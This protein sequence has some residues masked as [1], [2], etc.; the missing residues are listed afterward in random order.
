LFFSK[1]IVVSLLLHAPL[2]AQGHRSIRGEVLSPQPFLNGSYFAQLYDPNGHHVVERTPVLPGG[3][4]DFHDAPSGPC[5]V[6]I[7]TDG[8]DIVV[9][10]PVDS[11]A[12]AAPL[13][14]R[15]PEQNKPKAISGLVSLTALQH[16][17]THKA[18]S[19]VAKAEKFARANDHDQAIEHLRKATQ[20]SPEY[21]DAHSNLGTQYV[22]E[23]RFE[24]A[25]AEYRKAI[26]IGPG[27]PPQYCNLSIALFALKRVPEAEEAARRAVSLDPQSPVCN[28]VLARAL[29]VN[30]AKRAEAARHLAIAAPTIP[31]A[32]RFLAT[33]P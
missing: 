10:A 20:I 2:C 14:I 25:L 11:G 7:V 3:D 8:G 31:N 23:N 27:S 18:M 15:L 9:S 16:P 33:F 4:F 6:Q 24:E 19:E 22:Y 30:P 26:A 29:L 21:A 17:P 13:Q 28:Y 12:F 32:A 1:A 5:T